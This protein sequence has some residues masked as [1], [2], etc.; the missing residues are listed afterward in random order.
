MV[1]L[2]Q[3]IQNPACGPHNERPCKVECRVE[4]TRRDGEDGD[5]VGL[6][7][8]ITAGRGAC[9]GEASAKTGNER[10]RVVDGGKSEPVR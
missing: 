7:G 4:D 8:S 5:D 2:F 3:C 9:D 1:L 10:E 6:P